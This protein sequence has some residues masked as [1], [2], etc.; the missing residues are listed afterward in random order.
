MTASQRQLAADN[1]LLVY[2]FLMWM[3]LCATDASET[4]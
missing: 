1:H 3:H 2:K 4:G